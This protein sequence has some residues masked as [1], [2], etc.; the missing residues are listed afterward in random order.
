MLA[1]SQNVQYVLLEEQ[2][3]PSIPVRER[4]PVGLAIAAAVVSFVVTAVAQLIW[5]GP[6]AL[7]GMMGCQR[8]PCVEYVLGGLSVVV[9]I[10]ALAIGVAM[11]VYVLQGRSRRLLVGV[12]AGIGVAFALV[13]LLVF[14]LP[15]FI[16]YLLGLS[17]IATGKVG[18]MLIT[19]GLA[20]VLALV[21][22]GAGDV[23]RWV[24]LKIAGLLGRSM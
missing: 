16:L 7:V 10:P 14:P 24:W 13:D 17:G 12:A 8:G 3:Q 5:L 6:I 19:G 4:R 11:A 2:G 20:F 15:P 23:L 1:N 18:N 9:G 22:A 21:G